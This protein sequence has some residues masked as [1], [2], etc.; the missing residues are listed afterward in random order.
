MIR[1][2]W[3]AR[4]WLGG[5]EFASGVLIETNDQGV[6]AELTVGVA[7]DSD[8]TV[9][10]G[11]VL[12]GFVNNHSHAFHRALRGRT[13]ERSANF[14]SWRDQMYAL[15]ETLDPDSYRTLARAVYAEMLLAGYT[16]VTEFHYLHHAPGGVLYADQNAMSAALMEAA[17][18]VGIGM[19]LLDTLYLESA[20]GVAPNRVQMRFSDGDAAAWIDRTSAWAVPKSADQA[21]RTD[22]I[23]HG[24]AVHSIRAVPPHAIAAAAAVADSR[25]MPLHAHVSE[26]SQENLECIERYGRTPV[27]VFAEAGALG[28]RF[29]AVHAT[30]LTGN[31]ISLLGGSHVCMCP[32]TEA[33]L[34][35]GIGPAGALRDAGAEI[36]IGSD[37]Q[38]VIDPC[39]EMKRLEFDQRLA[40][41]QRGTFT[42]E[43]LARAGTR[44]PIR[45]GARADLVE[46]DPNSV[47]MSG[48]DGLAAIVFA[49]SAADVRTVIAG[50]R[51]C[52]RDGQHRTLDVA[53]ELRDSIA[54]AWRGVT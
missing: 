23:N 12:P 33:E 22:G 18:E 34:A 32:T 28:K 27:Q 7:A 45:V 9:L 1:K 43:A 37:S 35:D 44:G 29:T 30:H 53:A 15:A 4:A 5:S 52:V 14:W 6:I 20:P 31:D 11:W 2:V 51:E 49:A 54:T 3:C 10:S 40:S 17:S 24:L 13:Q 47:R 26:Q 25:S 36:S 50:G 19:T 21:T 46:F 16:H 8:A 38:A 48:A 42:P 39:E 41:G